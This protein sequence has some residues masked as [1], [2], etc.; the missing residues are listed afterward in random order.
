M[1]AAIYI[2]TLLYISS[3]ILALITGLPS[4]E[5]VPPP[6]ANLETTSTAGVSPHTVLPLYHLNPN[7]PNR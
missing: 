2:V 7:P 3:A 1:V 5:D 6:A 4:P